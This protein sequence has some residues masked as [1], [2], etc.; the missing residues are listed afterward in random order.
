MT[1]EATELPKRKVTFLTFQES[2]TNHDR[3]GVPDL[4]TEDLPSIVASLGLSNDG[5]MS[6]H[7]LVKLSS[8][9]SGICQVPNKEFQSLLEQISLKWKFCKL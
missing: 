6:L 9:G 2:H 4:H 8:R 3:S 7:T 5:R 1:T